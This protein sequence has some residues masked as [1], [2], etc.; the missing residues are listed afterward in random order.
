MDSDQAGGFGF[1]AIGAVVG[2]GVAD[3]EEAF[4]DE[5]IDVAALLVGVDGVGE[6]AGVGA[7]LSGSTGDQDV[8]RYEAFLCQTWSRQAAVK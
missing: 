5:A 2:F 3:A 6:V 4:G 7:G 8:S 1:M